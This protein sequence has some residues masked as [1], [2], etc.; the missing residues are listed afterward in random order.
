MEYVV[1][2]RAEVIKLVSKLSNTLKCG[3]R[4]TVFLTNEE[5]ITIVPPE[6]ISKG[7]SVIDA[8]EH[9]GG[10]VVVIENRFSRCSNI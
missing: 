6:A 1:S 7:L 4:V 3:E 9:S 10:I 2:T 5:L 8:Y